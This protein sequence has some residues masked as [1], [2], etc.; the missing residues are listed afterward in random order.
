VPT[1]FTSSTIV[2]SSAQ[3]TQTNLI[4]FE[5]G[6]E[7]RF[8]VTSPG[9]DEP[10]S[11]KGRL[12]DGTGLS[13][14]AFSMI[15][16]GY[17]DDTSL[18]S[19]VGA[20]GTTIVRMNETVTCIATVRRR[21]V[22]ITAIASDLSLARIMRGGKVLAG[23]DVSASKIY[24]TT[25]ASSRNMSFTFKAPESIGFFSVYGVV[26]G[27][28]SSF[29]PS[30]FKMLA[31]GN[32]DNTSTMECSGKEG[33]TTVRRSETNVLCQI[34][35][36]IEGVKSAGIAADFPEASTVGGSAVS[37]PV[38]GNAEGTKFNFTVTAPPIPETISH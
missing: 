6:N 37:K 31:V 17:P 13:G 29:P 7:V 35:P 14:P 15:V 23:R 28:G 4:G 30:G 27:A 25:G 20:E 2:P 1:D 11:V 21:N 9:V 12:N 33:T 38:V 8:N 22:S 24:G 32:P 10:F 18:L 36:K 19:C 26:K 34:T 3:S 5:D 16:V